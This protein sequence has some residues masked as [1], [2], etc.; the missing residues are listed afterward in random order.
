MGH[1]KDSR[2]GSRESR[3]LTT[4]LTKAVGVVGMAIIFALKTS[5]IAA[6]IVVVTTLGLSYGVFYEVLGSG[7]A[8]ERTRRQ[9]GIA[10]SWPAFV[11]IGVIRRLSGVS[12]LRD[13]GEI[14]GRLQMLPDGFRWTSSPRMAKRLPMPFI[15]WDKTWQLHFERIWGPGQQGHVQL[16]NPSGETSDIWIWGSH[17]FEQV[18]WELRARSWTPSNPN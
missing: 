4:F 10:P 7:A 1:E 18:T 11:E 5:P 16:S 3:R 17:D 12:G 6:D 8:K 2:Y 9:E 14:G 15:T 13:S